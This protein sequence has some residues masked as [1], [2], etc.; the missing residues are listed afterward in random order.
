MSSSYVL[1][2]TLPGFGTKQSTPFGSS[3]SGP[4]EINGDQVEF[5]IEVNKVIAIGHVVI[6]QDTTRLTADR[7][8]FSRDA[9]V[10]VAEGNV[11]LTSPQGK[12]SGDKLTYNFE[13]MTGDFARAKLSSSPYYGFSPIASKVAENQ[14]TLRKG[15]ITTC[16]LAKPHFRLA[17]KK[18]DIYPKDKMVAR[19]MRMI[20]GKVPILYIHK[21]VQA[22]DGKPRVVF[23]P[24]YSKAWGA[25]L[26]QQWRYYFNDDFKGTIHLDYREKKAVAPGVDLK[27]KITNGGE[28]LVRLYYMNELTPGYKHFWRQFGAK[29]QNNK[30]ETV[31]R[32]RFRAQWRHKWSVDERTDITLQY[33][34]LRD[35]TFLKD[36][37][38]REYEKDTNPQTYF[39]LTKALDYGTFSFRADGRVNRFAGGTVRLPE[40]RYDITNQQIG[41]TGLYFKSEDSFANL[42]LKAASPTEVRKETMRLDSSNEISYP[43]KI[44]FVEV[45][46]FV[47]GRE[48]YYSKTNDVSRYNIV[49][50]IFRTGSSLSTKFFKIFDIKTKLCGIDIN[51]LRHVITPTISYNYTHSPT[52]PSTRLD[53]FDG[54]DSLSKAHNINFDLE[55]KLQT[56]RAG[57]IVDLLRT[58]V[59][60]PFLLKEDNTAKGGFDHVTTNTELRPTAK[61]S[62]FANSDYDTR[63]NRLVSANFDLYVNDKQDKSYFSI[64]QRYSPRVDDQITTEIGYVINPKWRLRAYRRF[65]VAHG[66]IKGS[67]KEQ[68]FKLT[69]DLHCWELEVNFNER[70]GVG[71]E[72]WLVFRLKAFPDLTFDFGN[73]FNRR[74][75]GSQAGETAQ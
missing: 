68:E 2:E 34:K 54:I 7:V 64:G 37:F 65:D 50:G 31:Q 8:E 62:F 19:N 9:K 21:H 24:G 17:S 58:T 25:Y 72:I 5:K 40:L 46:P 57:S 59:S 43:L 10:A 22:L 69:R 61:L 27:Y 47:G 60:T 48:T 38:R 20:I 36:Y 32:E 26:L 6:T 74:K 39:L 16:D 29:Y 12:I 56:K 14:I 55:N 67:L 18:I 45:R 66:D 35:G 52:V 41:H 42:S 11:V 51:R 63:D 70:R 1:A 3:Q 75:T 30:I 73:S 15:Y 71:S 23:T 13:T 44:S 33:F 49:R 28:G 4:I 53:S